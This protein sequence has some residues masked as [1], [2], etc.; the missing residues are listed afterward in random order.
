[1]KSIRVCAEHS[2]P[3]GLTQEPPE[4]VCLLGYERLTIEE[5]K[6]VATDYF[7]IVRLVTSRADCR[8][9]PAQKKRKKT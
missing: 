1:M 4:F 2:Y 6:I 8:P 5:T 7:R 9:R 3:V